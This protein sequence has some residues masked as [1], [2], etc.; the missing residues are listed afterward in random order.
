MSRCESGGVLD[1]RGTLV[2][3]DNGD[4]NLAFGVG[5]V[6]GAVVD[7]PYALH[8][9]VADEALAAALLQSAGNVPSP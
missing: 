3:A 2:R 5:C 4:P 9:D 7:R 6:A 1:E 8:I